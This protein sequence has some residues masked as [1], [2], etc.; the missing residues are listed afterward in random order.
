MFVRFVLADL[1]R[2]PRRTLSTTVGVLLGIGLFCAV[3]FFVD[4]LSASM[5]QRAVAPLP[6]DMQRVLTTPLAKDLE[7]RLMVEPTGHAQPGDV[8]QIQLELM[9]NGKTPANEVTVRSAPSEALAYVAGSAVV[10]SELV[11][12]GTDNPFAKGLAQAGLN[13]GA[14]EPGTSVHLG[15]QATVLTAR[16]VSPEAFASAFSTREAV[17]P[18]EANADAPMALA[19]LTALIRELDGVAFAEQLSFVDLAPGALTAGTSIVAPPRV[20]GFDAGYFAH[21]KTIKI[22]EGAQTEGAAMIS[23]EAATEL[24]VGVGDSVSLALPDKSQM[25]ARISGILDLSQARSL[26]TSRRGADLE[27]FSYRPHVVVIDSAQFA[28]VIVPAFERAATTTGRR[29]KNPPVREVDIGVERELLDAEPGVALGQ[30]QRIAAAISSVGG[31]GRDFLLDNIS[32]TLT[33]ARDDAM[34]AKRMFVFLGAPGAMLAAMLAAYAG[35]VLGSTQRRERATLRM[36]GASRS[37]LLSMLAL[38]VSCITAAGALAGAALGYASAAAVIGHDALT[39]ATMTSLLI[40]AVLGALVGL[41]ATGAAL[42]LTGRRSID[43]EINEDRARLWRR[44]PAWRRYLLDVAAMVAVAAATVFVIMTSGFKGT[45]GTIYDARSVELPLALLFLPLGFWVAGSFFGGRILGWALTRPQAEGSG[46]LDRP[47]ALLYRSSV[48]RRSESL[49]DAA[50]ILA[51]IVSLATSVAVFTASYDEAKA[52]DA[53]FTL[54]SDLR[55]TPGPASERIYRSDDAASFAVPGVGTV[56]PVVFGGHTAVLR[57]SRAAEL[58]NLAAVDPAT[59]AQVAP[60]DDSHFSSGSA[61]EAMNMLADQPNGVLVSNDLASFLTIAAG[62]KVRV[63]LARNTA[64]NVMI[65][66]DV[67]GMFE[68]LPGFPDG[69]QA[70]MNIGRHEAMVASTRPA[71][72]L[73]Q[74]TDRSDAA[75]ADVAT[76]LARGPGADGMLQIDTRLTTLAKEQSSLA[77]LNIGGLLRLDSAYALAM[78]TV[79]IAIFVFGLM[80]QRRRE[81]VTLRALGMQPA[82]IRSLIAAEAGTAVLAGCATGIPVG[83]IMAYYFVNVLRPL[84]VLTPPYLVPFGSLALVAASILVT[85]IVTSAAASSLVN[86]MR[87]TELLRDD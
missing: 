73:L 49:V 38:R 7:L 77:A 54:G 24:S 43:L 71:F 14:V 4:G 87:A 53:R 16:D 1:V 62:D 66:M 56:A 25:T 86:R 76:A 45:P 8:I 74:T 64:E 5:T 29:L 41:L 79:T 28:K 21:D 12:A 65:E 55:I 58:I 32:N 50:I 26:F 75:L 40:S 48:R 51:L 84:F 11:A 3:L 42:Y 36:R 67:I 47:L 70:L 33:V 23:V 27:T 82:A 63:L 68:R 2:N 72:F 6:I 60:L 83:L 9:N 78:G 30:T 61:R 39:R 22:V 17:F 69:A 80:L 52:V 44:L 31:A 10:E 19:E 15:Y 59:Y 57:S 85:T 18:I 34:V 46:Y 13:I 20:F 35:V 81:Y 37:H